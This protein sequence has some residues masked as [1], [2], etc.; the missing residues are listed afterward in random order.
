MGN[1]RFLSGAAVMAA[2]IAAGPA[3]HAGHGSSGGY[4]SSGGGYAA[5]YGSY[6]GSSGGY[7][8]VAD[9]YGSSGGY[10]AAYGSSGGYDHG[11]GHHGRGHVGPLRRL[12]HRLHA[13][14]AAKASYASYGSSGGGYASTGGYGS[15][16]GYASY[17]SSGGGASY[18][19]S[20]GAA[21]YYKPYAASY[22][23]SGGYGSTG[24]YAPAP[25]YYYEDSVPYVAPD[26]QYNPSPA[27]DGGQ[28]AEIGE[29]SVLM[30]VA[31]PETAVVHVNGLPTSSTGPIR[32]F[33]SKGLKK[34]LLYK[35]EVEVFFEGAD[36]P[37]R[38]TVKMRAGSTERMVFNAPQTSPVAQS[39]ADLETVVTIRVP[40]DAKVVLAGNETEGQGEVRTFRSRKLAAGQRW[41]GYTIRVSAEVN[42]TVVNQERTLDLVAGSAHDVSFDF[43]GT[44]VASR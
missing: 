40:A 12:I 17:A 18:G 32:Q 8:S 26:Q 14:H 4:G 21:S 42:G 3:A 10:A 16:G 28:A 39:A 41:E 5:S 2:A 23:S 9:S 44:K 24:G 20:G 33:M 6:G 11:H 27:T 15:N 38:R 34:D 19:S 25:T 29:D 13:H 35:Y 7:S 37:V 30:T 22:G 1:L 31:V 43:D 36:E